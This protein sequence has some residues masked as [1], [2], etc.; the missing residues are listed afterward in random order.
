MESPHLLGFSKAGSIASGL[1]HLTFCGKDKLGI[2]KTIPHGIIT[3]QNAL[4][5]FIEH[6]RKIKYPLSLSRQLKI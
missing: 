2:K 1:N 4:L 5:I 3:I 6:I